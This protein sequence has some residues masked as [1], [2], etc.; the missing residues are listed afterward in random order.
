MKS[1]RI[2]P[3]IAG[4]LLG[5]FIDGIRKFASARAW[6]R[7]AQT[8]IGASSYV[9][10]HDQERELIEHNREIET[11]AEMVEED[12]PNAAKHL[13]MLVNRFPY[14]VADRQASA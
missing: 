13:R 5:F 2:D 8:P 4:L 1:L 7:R 3:F 11:A 12:C 6:S 14:V 10:T 9:L